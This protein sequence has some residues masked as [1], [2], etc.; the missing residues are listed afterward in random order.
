[1]PKKLLIVDD[2]PGVTKVV[3]LIARRLGLDFRA[4]H[5]PR[6]AVAE[7]VEY[8]PDFLILDMIMPDLDGI[9]VLNDIILTGYPARIVLTSGHGEAYMALAAG[10]ARFHGIETPPILR[11]P[12]RRE[13]L[14]RLLD[15]PIH[16][17]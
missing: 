10:V 6:Q 5:D 14:E 16:S 1:M 11:K 3:S 12:F 7:F 13:E 4:V 9:D 8:Q 15:V 17:C 2:Q